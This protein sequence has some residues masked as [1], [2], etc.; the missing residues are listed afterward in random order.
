MSRR[1]VIIPK[2]L[3]RKLTRNAMADPDIRDLIDG[4]PSRSLRRAD[5]RGYQVYMSDRIYHEREVYLAADMGLGKTAAVLWAVRRLLDEGVV[6]K[7]LIIAPLAVANDTWPDE[8]RV[9]TFARPMKFSLL[10]GEEEERTA[11]AREPT[12]IHIINRENVLWL[13]KWLSDQGIAWPYDMIVYDEASRLKAGRKRSKG[14]TRADGTKSAPKMNEFGALSRVRN[15]VE[16]IVELS[17][18]PAPK[19]LVDLWGPFYILD[20]GKRLGSS[21]T[22]F[23]NRWFQQDRYS[24]E[25]T[26]FLHSE[27]EIMESISDV[28]VALREE[29]YLTLPPLTVDDRYVT[30]PDKVLDQYRRFERT[31]YCEEYDVEAVNAG[32]LTN[33][34]LQF[35]NGSLYVSED[36]AKPIH[37]LKLDALESIV[38][39]TA[40]EPL[41]IA[42]SFRF[43]LDRIRKRFP[44]F[45]VYG[46]SRSDMRDWNAGKIPGLIVHP[47]SA[48]HGLNFQFGGHHA[49]WYGLNWSLELYQQFNK[50][51]HRSGQ[52]AER[53]FLHRILAR[54]TEDENVASQLIARGATQD[55]IKDHVRLRAHELQRLAA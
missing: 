12:E 9:W 2:V 31:L 19:G 21:R 13:Y 7:V 43:D 26:P 41:L 30:L 40:G 24:Y 38:E 11:A 42:Y 37:D 36:E 49:V 33:K 22:A 47:A 23:L 8:F 32:V 27:R 18:T 10:T 5:F 25:I 3:R 53:V 39:E 50:R 35:A 54:R 46:E 20:Q 1:K 4:P 51:L 29:D 34:L 6:R 17:G 44:K 14:S 16:R 52:K 55:A 15:R 45:R 48:G 28:M